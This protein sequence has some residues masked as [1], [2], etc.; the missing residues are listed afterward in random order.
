MLKAGRVVALDTTKNLL[1]RV[2]GLTV[3][4]VAERIPAAWEPRVTSR[5][6]QIFILGLEQYADLESLL[7]ALRVESIHIDELALQETD[8]E[9]VFLQIMGAGRPRAGRA[10]S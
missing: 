6:G 8:L 5:D 4:L 7:A 1:T 2:A 3:R 9:Q 10:P